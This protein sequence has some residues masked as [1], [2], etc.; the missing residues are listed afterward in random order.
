MTLTASSLSLAMLSYLKL[1]QT[2]NE[3]DS[4]LRRSGIFVEKAIL[5]EAAQ[6]R[7]GGRFGADVAPTELEM[8]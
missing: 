5:S 8:F 6:P 2:T 4:Q 7:R 1:R 3:G